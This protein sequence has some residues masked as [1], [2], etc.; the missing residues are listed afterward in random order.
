MGVA[1]KVLR[2]V[3]IAIFMA[4]LMIPIVWTL[5]LS[6]KPYLEWRAP[7]F[8]PKNPTLLNYKILFFYQREIAGTTGGTALTKPMITPL[9]NT[10]IVVGVSTIIAVIIGFFTAYG[11]SRYNSPGPFGLYFTLLTRMVPPATFV[12]PVLIYYRMIGFLDTQLGL[13][14]L[15]AAATVTYSIW[16]LKGFID[17]IPREWEEAAILEGLSPLRA[18]LRVTLPLIKSALVVSGLFIFLMN[19]SEFL[20][21]LVLTTRNAVTL[22][23][24]LTT[25]VGGSGVLYG[26]Q[27]ACGIVASIIPLVIGYVIQRHL[28]TG[29]T[30]GMVRA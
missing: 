25:Y 11:A 19:Y 27:A 17:Q 28:I 15:Y 1:S 8:W 13:I 29:L 2:I 26:A 30:F 16:I 5:S 4:W 20:F 7:H 6:F 21:A 24:H 18:M 22:P 23:V 10:L 12:T 3:A 9:I 14:L